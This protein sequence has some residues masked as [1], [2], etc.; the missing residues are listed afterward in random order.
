MSDPNAL[1]LKANLKALK[2]PTM[3]AEYD[4]LA[5]EAASRN[6]S[7]DAFLLRLTELEVATRTANAIAARI[8]TAA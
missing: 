2:L 5:R 1:L 7:Y 6:E 3:L 8:R 4:Q